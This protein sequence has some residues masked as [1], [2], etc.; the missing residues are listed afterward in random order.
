MSYQKIFAVVNEHTSSTVAARYA[1]ALAA[2]VNA[3]LVLYTAHDE[4]TN[5]LSLRHTERH[6]DHL[7]T[8]AFELGVSVTRITETGTITAQLS[9]RVRAEGADLVFYPLTPNERYGALMHR[10]VAGQLLRTVKADLAIMR[11][12]HMGKPYPRNILVPLGGIINDLERR[13]LFVSALA[14]CFHARVTI[15]HRPEGGRAKKQPADI[16][17]FRNDLQEHHVKILERSRKGHIA[18]AIILEA[19]TRHNDLIVLGASERGFLN[20]LFFGSPSGD[21]M[22]HPPCN[23]ILF[24]ASP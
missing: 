21:V 12:V 18:K 17:R 23:A 1:I 19:I 15:F 3:A 6:L 7:H 20:R 2:S 14:K 16:A 10:P 24:R 22:R 8:V 13:R 11:I 5:E 9:K 4:G